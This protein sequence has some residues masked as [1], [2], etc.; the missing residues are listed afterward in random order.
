M[1]CSVLSLNRYFRTK[2]QGSRSLVFFVYVH[3]MVVV[4]WGNGKPWTTTAAYLLNYYLLSS[5]IAPA[6]RTQDDT[7]YQVYLTWSR[8]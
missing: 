5:R 3:V 7:H 2:T 8:E 1:I 4:C 6:Q